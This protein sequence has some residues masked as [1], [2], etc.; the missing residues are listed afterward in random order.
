MGCKSY[1]GTVIEQQGTLWNKGKDPCWRGVFYIQGTPAQRGDATVVDVILKDGYIP[2]GN[3]RVRADILVEDGKIAGF[4]N[5]SHGVVAEKVISCEGRLVVPGGV[6]GHTHFNEL[7]FSEREGFLNGTAAAAAGGVTTV[8]DMPDLPAVRSA[9]QFDRKAAAVKDKAY[10]DYGFWGGMTGEDVREGWTDR[11]Y[12]QIDR[13]VCS[14]KL[15]MTPSV[16]TYPRV[17]DAEMLELFYKLAPTGIPV[18]IHAENFIIADYYVKKFQ[19]E[20]RMEGPAWAE[21]RTRVAERVAIQMVI[22]FAAETGARA[23]IV[24]MSTRDG[25]ELIR[26]AKARGISVTAETCPHYLKLTAE[27]AMTEFGSLA[28]IAPPL[29][30]EDDIEALWEGLRDGTVDF[31]GTDHAP[32]VV[33]TEKHAPGMDIWTSLPG[34]PGVE[35]LMPF[36]VSEGLNKGR[37]SLEQFVRVTSRHSAIH[38]GLYPKK[39]TME[40]GA[41]ADFAIVDDT[42]TWVID[43]QKLHSK[44]QYTPLQGLALTGKIKQTVLRGTVVYDDARD[45]VVAPGTGQFVPRQSVQRLA[46]WLQH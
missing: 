29:R 22:S 23:H 35:T 20:G 30:T 36:M 28:K 10:I 39:G 6:D 1:W 25:V 19:R 32:Y 15:Y 42:E 13:G 17:D 26:E 7:E 38:Y 41:D 11:V 12:E 5:A 3:R 2:Q 44:A 46:R 27:S 4:V 34:I 9:A 16:P 24:H 43:P 45:L 21:A 40:I 33:A 31:M 37:L 14:F 18:G 8:V